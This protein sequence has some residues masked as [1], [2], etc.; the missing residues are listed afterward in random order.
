MPRPQC[1]KLV[2]RGEVAVAVADNIGHVEIIGEEQINQ[3]RHA[4]RDQKADSHARVSSALDEQRA[5]GD[6]SSNA[7]GHCIGRRDKGQKQ[8]EGSEEVQRSSALQ[9][10]RSSSSSPGRT[11]NRRPRFWA[12]RERL[13]TSRRTWLGLYRQRR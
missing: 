7:C 5:A 4:Q 13:R 8:G 6:D 2:K 10:R 1:G 12:V 11:P 3:A 9:S